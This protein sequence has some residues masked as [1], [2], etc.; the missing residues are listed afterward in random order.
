MSG[1]RVVQTW[2]SVDVVK[3]AADLTIAYLG[4]EVVERVGDAETAVTSI[5]VVGA[6]SVVASSLHV[7]RSQ[8][9]R[10]VV[11]QRKQTLRQLRVHHLRTDTI[12]AQRLLVGR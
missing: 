10:H 12:C 5:V 1:S 8:V 3:F 7:E 4:G 11:R 9:Q 6:Q 2:M